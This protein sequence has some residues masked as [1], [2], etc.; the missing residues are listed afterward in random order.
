VFGQ[1][2]LLDAGIGIL[3]D[4]QSGGVA[5]LIGAAQTAMRV[6]NTFKGANLASIAKNEAVAIGTNELIKAI[7][8]ATKQVMNRGGGVYIP[9]PQ[10]T[11]QSA[12][13]NFNP[14]IR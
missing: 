8:S 7:P 13:P 4:L 9:T 10:R 5:G 6:S 1:G 12:T 2:G 3:G 14:N 11:P